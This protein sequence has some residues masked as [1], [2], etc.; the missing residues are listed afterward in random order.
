LTE[1]EFRKILLGS[2]SIAVFSYVLLSFLFSLLLLLLLLLLLFVIIFNIDVHGSQPFL[3]RLVPSFFAVL[4]IG[5]DHRYDGGGRE[6]P[7]P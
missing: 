7:R 1:Q 2:K 6:R 4:G 3:F 5:E